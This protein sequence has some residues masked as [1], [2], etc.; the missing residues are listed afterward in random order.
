MSLEE[1]TPEQCE[2]A[3]TGVEEEKVK[4]ASPEDIDERIL[5][6]ANKMKEFVTKVE[7]YVQELAL[8]V[9]GLVVK[10]IETFL[11]KTPGDEMAAA[12]FLTSAVAADLLAHH[13]GGV[14][15]GAGT[16]TEEVCKGDGHFFKTFK[17]LYEERLSWYI[18]QFKE[19]MKNET[20]VPQS[21]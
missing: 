12:N 17:E 3:G 4:F 20:P 11:D 8:E 1:L 5:E 13:F 15:G 6:H 21:D 16:L 18:A 9:R 19:V 7:D 10:R 14:I 2:A